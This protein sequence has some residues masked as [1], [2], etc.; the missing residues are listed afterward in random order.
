MTPEKVKARFER[1][2]ITVTQWANDNHFSRRSVS[3]VLNGQ[4]KGK[5]GVSHRIA[6]ALGIKED[7]KGKK[8]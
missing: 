8:A 6:V 3:H 4:L 2:G 7:P 5:R 1:E